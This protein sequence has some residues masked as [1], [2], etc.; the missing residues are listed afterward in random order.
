MASARLA[1]GA[2]EGACSRKHPA[3]SG[4]GAQGQQCKMEMLDPFF[5]N[6]SQF[7]DSDHRASNAV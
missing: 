4:A 6:Y 1:T 7:Q 2:Q 3:E 5:K